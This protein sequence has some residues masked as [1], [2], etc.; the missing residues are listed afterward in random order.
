MKVNLVFCLCV[1]ES[2]K[3]IYTKLR[4]SLV[5]KKI[6]IVSLTFTDMFLTILS[7]IKFNSINFS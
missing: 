6:M 1:L 4:N 2:E 7:Y 3:N 5:N